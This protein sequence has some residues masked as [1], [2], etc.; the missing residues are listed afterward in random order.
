ALAVASGMTVISYCYG[1]NR[2]DAFDCASLP[3][4]VRLG[5]L[6]DAAGKA[7]CFT[8]RVDGGCLLL[9]H[10]RWFFEEQ[11]EVPDPI[12]VRMREAIV[13]QKGLTLG[14]LGGLASALRR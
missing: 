7:F 3:Q 2:L 10:A 5:D 13:A 12:L 6:L 14:D 9:R 1:S 11:R 4:N 8:W